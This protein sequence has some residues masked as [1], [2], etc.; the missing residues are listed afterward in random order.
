MGRRRTG[1]VI[2]GAVQAIRVARPHRMTIR[3]DAVSMALTS[4]AN[5]EGEVRTASHVRICLSRCIVKK[6]PRS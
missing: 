2:C 5:F 4:F 3:L 1:D 6:I